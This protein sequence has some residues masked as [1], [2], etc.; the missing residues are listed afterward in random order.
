MAGHSAKWYILWETGEEWDGAV[1]IF[2]VNAKM[3][4][5]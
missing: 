5:M 1:S 2:T 3:R 4:M